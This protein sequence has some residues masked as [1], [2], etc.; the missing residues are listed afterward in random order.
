MDRFGNQLLAGTAFARQQD[1]D[2]AGG[3]APDHL[4]HLLD[5][6]A[7]PDDLLS[8]VGVG[9][10]QDLELLV[11]VGDAPCFNGIRYD[12]LEPGHIE[13]L[14]Q[15]FESAVF[16]GGDNPFGGSEGRHDDDRKL[17]IHRFDPLDGFQPVEPGHLNIHQHQVRRIFFY[18]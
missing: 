6:R 2:I 13:R 11:L 17:R 14:L 7:H 18:S 15:V 8:G 16:H 3:H 12:R 10:R 1:A 9:C 4:V 5:G